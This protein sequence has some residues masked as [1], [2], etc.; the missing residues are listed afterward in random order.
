MHF[1]EEVGSGVGRSARQK[2]RSPS[3][4]NGTGWVALSR[5]RRGEGCGGQ[6]SPTFAPLGNFPENRKNT[7][8]RNGTDLVMFW[9]GF[10]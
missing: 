4:Y 9:A 8:R 5:W 10:T 6:L 2:M 1:A 3:G 7:G